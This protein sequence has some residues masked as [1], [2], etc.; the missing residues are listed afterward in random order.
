MLNFT[1]ST[2]GCALFQYPV[3]LVSSMKPLGCHSLNLKGPEPT[4]VRCRPSLLVSNDRGTIAIEASDAKSGADGSFKVRTTVDASCAV[5]LSSAARRLASGDV[6]S[7]DNTR[8]KLATTSAASSFEPS[9]NVAPSTS[10]N[11]YVLPSGDTCHDCA[12]PGTTRKSLSTPV[13]P[14]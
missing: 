2:F 5:A 9:W 11:V 6:M 1:P 12:S 8:L 7:F 4:G 3:C 10:L 14:S 13:S